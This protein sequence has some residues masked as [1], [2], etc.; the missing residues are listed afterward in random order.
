MRPAPAVQSSSE[1]K[2]FAPS[3]GPLLSLDRLLWTRR[4]PRLSALDIARAQYLDLAIEFPFWIRINGR[5]VMFLAFKL[6]DH[7]DRDVPP[8]LIRPIHIRGHGYRRP[9][10]ELNPPHYHYVSSELHQTQGLSCLYGR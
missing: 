5:K 4:P 9:V 8:P 10:D 1:R 2:F 7:A 6:S 3:A